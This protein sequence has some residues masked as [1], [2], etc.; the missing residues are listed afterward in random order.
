MFQRH[1]VQELH[2]E[3]RV[4]VLLPDFMDRADIRMV[5]GRGARASRW[6]RANAWESLAS[7]GRLHEPSRLEKGCY[8][9]GRSARVPA[10]RSMPRNLPD[11]PET[12]PRAARSRSSRYAAAQPPTGTITATMATSTGSSASCSTARK[13]VAMT[14]RHGSLTK[15]LAATAECRHRR[16]SIAPCSRSASCRLAGG[17]QALPQH[18]LP[19]RE[20]FLLGNLAGI[21]VGQDRA[22]APCSPCFRCPP[23]SAASATLC[24]ARRRTARAGARWRGTRGLPFAPW[25]FD[26]DAEVGNVGAV[27]GLQVA[28]V[29][30]ILL[31]DADQHVLQRDQRCRPGPS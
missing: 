25:S 27:F 3:E 22:S 21:D 6:K 4:A 5:E 12:P 9:R 29:H 26:V 16:R 8:L 24:G 30:D 14:L 28:A 31:G 20:Q 2:D 15:G 17:L 10:P 23:C 18:L 11:L 13:L 19:A 7:H 1:A